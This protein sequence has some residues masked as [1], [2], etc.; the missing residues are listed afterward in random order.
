LKFK[1]QIGFIL[2]M[3]LVFYLLYAFRYIDNN[4]LT[5]WK[6]VFTDI[7]TYLLTLFLIMSLV[8]IGFLSRISF[9]EQC[10][11]PLLFLLSFITGILFWKEPEIIVDASR[12]FIYAKHM[13]EADLVFK[14]FGECRLYI[15]CFNTVLFSMTVILTFLIGKTLWNREVGVVAGILMAGFPYLFTQIPLMLVDV[16]VMFFLTLSVF[17]MLKAMNQGSKLISGFSSLAIFLTF[18]SKFSTWPMISVTAL[19]ILVNMKAQPGKMLCRGAFILFLFTVLTTM[20]LSWKYEVII[21]QIKLLQTYQWAGLSRW[22]ES[23][24]STFLFQTHPFVTIAA[25]YSVYAALKKKI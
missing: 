24:V 23:P 21:K 12:Y 1:N 14:F 13:E 17:S 25:C 6:W 18:F 9:S 19:I 22:G 8:I 20:A 15:Q 7:N 4:R 2:L 11:A 10:H 5:S 16:P 3:L